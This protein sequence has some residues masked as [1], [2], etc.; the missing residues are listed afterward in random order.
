MCFPSPL[1]SRHLAMSGDIGCHSSDGV[2]VGK[3][4]LTLAPTGQS[5]GTLLNLL[6]RMEQLPTPKNNLVPNVHT[7]K[8]LR[9]SPMKRASIPIAAK[10]E[11]LRKKATITQLSIHLN[12]W[13][14]KTILFQNLGIKPTLAFMIKLNKYHIIFCHH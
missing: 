10:P 6:H 2:V 4:A 14:K 8:F 11:K 9:N 3:G 5:S 1:H 7:S 12:A 13:M